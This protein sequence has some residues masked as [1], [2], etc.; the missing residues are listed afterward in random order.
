MSSQHYT[1]EKL[2]ETVTFA[3]SRPNGGALSNSGL[4]DLGQETVVF[5]TSLTPQAA[6][7]LRNAA[8]DATGRA[9]SIA[10]N[11][12]WHLDHVLGNQLFSTIPTWGTRRTREILVEQHDVL[13]AE[14][15]IDAMSKTVRE[16]EEIV[17]AAG[18]SEVRGYLQTVL[19]T[20]RWVLAASPTLRLTAPN[21][22]FED[23]VRLQAGN[24]AELLTFGS[25][26][27]ESDALLH[28]PRE[29][30]LFAGDLIVVGT[31]P[32]L[33]S[34]DPEHWLK[35]LEQIDGLR[36]ERI[37]PGHGPVSGADAIESVRDYVSTL[38]TIAREPGPAVIP[39]RFDG[40]SGEDQFEENV[41]FL[42]SR[43]PARRLPDA[44]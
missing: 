11:S 1:F 30:L 15:G 21:Q 7:D 19:D 8:V 32:N 12:H 39:H 36:P 22:T 13:S 6:A 35:V 29:G 16:L 42:R 10:V 34:G 33:T 43:P 27:T 24:E 26:H 5:D 2:S 28:L 17:A 37:V 4:I 44:A 41:K 31:H 23:R 40:W 3:R 20:H 38:L 25:G 14:L 9:P 18:T